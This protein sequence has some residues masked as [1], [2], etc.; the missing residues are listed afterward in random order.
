M[1]SAPSLPQPQ[2]RSRL[3]LT[4]PEQ[5]L[6]AVPYLLGFRPE[7]SVV[8]MSLRGK[9]VGLTM[10]LDLDTPPRELHQLVVNRLR[11][12]GATRAVIVLFD[13]EDPAGAGVGALPGDGIA[14]ALM[15]AV[16]R[17][18]LD[19]VDAIVV[20]RGRFRSCLCTNPVCCPPGGRPVPTGGEADHSLVASAFVALGT[21]PMASREELRASINPAPPERRLALLPAIEEA[22]GSPVAHSVDAWREVVQRYLETSPREPLSDAEIACLVASLRNVI[23]RDEVISWTAGED[24]SA[25]LAVLREL[26]PLAPAPFDTQ[27]L[28]SLAWAAY[29][30]GD[31]ALA[32]AALDRALETDPEHSLSRLLAVALEHG[33]SPEKLRAVGGQLGCDLRRQESRALRRRDAR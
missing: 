21:A 2:S 12:D 28:A 27:V 3:R 7:R 26:A 10:R 6:T 15:R 16:R 19:V 25:V 17:A 1:A 8:V 30:F 31:G 5:I 32:A 11:A 33:V 13:P 14:R 23:V 9:Q 18:R 24:L 20:H 4:S 22:L 29:S